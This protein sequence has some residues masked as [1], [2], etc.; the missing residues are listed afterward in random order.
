MNLRRRG[1]KRPGEPTVVGTCGKDSGEFAGDAASVERAGA[2]AVGSEAVEPERRVRETLAMLAERTRRAARWRFVFGS[3]AG[4]TYI[5]SQAARILHCVPAFHR[6]RLWINVELGLWLVSI[7]AGSIGLIAQGFWRRSARLL[8]ALDDVRCAGPLL[9]SMA[10][11]S[12]QHVLSRRAAPNVEPVLTRILS[13]FAPSDNALLTQE[14]LRTVYGLLGSLDPAGH[15]DFMIAALHAVAQVG[16]AEAIPTVA[17]LAQKPSI[18]PRTARVRNAAR[19]CMPLLKSRAGDNLARRTLLRPAHG[20]DTG[21]EQL[22]RPAGGEN[23]AS[24]NLL[25]PAGSDTD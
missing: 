8:G 4:L 7:L 11:A 25:H 19:E 6:G 24:D 20:V 12:A 13:R 23:P 1:E 9:E 2:S 22:L 15:T 10:Q 14:Q 17:K 18:G 3:V 16:D 21:G 5:G